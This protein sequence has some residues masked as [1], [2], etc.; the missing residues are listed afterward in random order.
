MG[1][2]LLPFI[3]ASLIYLLFWLPYFGKTPSY[4][5]IF[6][7]CLPILCLICFVIAYLKG[8]SRKRYAFSILAGLVLSCMG[9]ACLV[10]SHNWFIEG[11]L[12]FALGHIMYAYAFGHKPYRL[13][14]LLF[15]VP[16]GICIYAF[17]LPGFKGALT[18]LGG[19]YIILICV[20]A[21]RAAAAIQLNMWKWTKIFAFWG[22]VMFCISDLVLAINK[23]R[24]E[25]PYGDTIVMSTYY[26]AQ[27]GIALSVVPSDTILHKLNGERR[28][29]N[30]QLPAVKQ[31]GER[32]NSIS[33]GEA[34]AIKQDW[35]VIQRFVFFNLWWQEL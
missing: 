19:V 1:F 31:N 5:N 33:K 12:C 34:K 32:R 29:S 20:M 13:Q 9:D 6:F 11:L 30:G 16:F 4:Q 23:F 26:T 25:V 17:M 27:L 8:L 7:K 2:R 22:A 24:F 21:W 35:N 14:M 15:L 18:Y 28:L 10:Y 3:K